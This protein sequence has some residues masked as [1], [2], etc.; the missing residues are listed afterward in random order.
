MDTESLA[1]T[2]T[3]R[4]AYEAAQTLILIMA[5]RSRNTTIWQWNCRGFARK[6]PVLQQFL[7]SRDRPEIIALQEGGKHAQ[8]AGYKTYT[9]GRANSQHVADATTDIEVEK[10]V[11]SCDRHYAKL[12][13]RKRKLETLLRT[14]KWDKDIRRR[15]ARSSSTPT[16]V[17]DPSSLFLHIRG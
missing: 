6:R 15:L 11:P 13:A 9:S 2:A 16:S 7:A 14:R 3:K 5:G 1:G 8:L 4:K 10:S 17:L 12:W